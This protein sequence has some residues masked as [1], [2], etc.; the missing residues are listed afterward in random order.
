MDISTSSMI[1]AGGSRGLGLAVAEALCA[2][3]AS[4]T[5]VARDRA[6]LDAA[7]A[8]LPVAVEQADV[9]DAAA[10]GGLMA[11]IR[12]DAVVFAAGAVPPM[13]PINEISWADFSAT[14][15]TDAR[16]ALVWLQA[17]LNLPLRK[18]ARF[19]TMSSGA[20]IGGSPMSGG[21]GGAK[22][23]QWLA[24]NY[25]AA[26]AEQTGLG[27]GFQTFVVGQ[28]IG[29]T[30]VGDAG[31]AAYAQQ[32]GITPAQFMQRFGK[33]LTPTDVGEAVARV[34]QEPALAAPRAL[35]LRGDDGLVVL[36][37]AAA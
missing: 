5:I 30:A 18:G 7:Q 13:A 6:R 12:P 21:Y 25:A 9:T 10:A 4:V 8:R 34:L 15:E 27:I 31:A 24:T 17:A 23:M 2:R 22:R 35:R 28:M 37:P 11:R 19:L 1:V 36:E 3:G 26:F 33:P 20:A 16:G 32:L 29:G 14:W